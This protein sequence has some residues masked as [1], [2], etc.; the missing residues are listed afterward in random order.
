MFGRDQSGGQC[1]S[2]AFCAT[3]TN[4]MR[5]QLRRPLELVERLVP[6][7]RDEELTVP[8]DV[9]ERLRGRAASLAGRPFYDRYAPEYLNDS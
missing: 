2:D 5:S 3:S 7:R 6:G 8:P 1:V 9:L 4:G